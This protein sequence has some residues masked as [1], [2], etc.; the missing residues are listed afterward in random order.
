V[1]KIG[2][3]RLVWIVEGLYEK[4][5]HNRRFSLPGLQSPEV[6]RNLEQLYPEKKPEDLVKDYYVKKIQW[7]LGILL[8]GIVLA[9]LWW[10]KQ[11]MQDASPV[12]NVFPRKSF[13]EGSYQG[14]VTARYAG[15]KETFTLEIHPRTLN[16]EELEN[17]Y[18]QFCRN[19]IPLIKGKNES[20]QEIMSDLCL[21]DSYEGYPFAIQWKSS[22]PQVLRSSGE[23][24]L[25]EQTTEAELKA[26]LCYQE[27]NW[28]ISLPV[29][30]LSQEEKR[31]REGGGSDYERMR[32]QLLKMEEQS[33]DT[34][35]F[36]LPNQIEDWQIEW[37]TSGKGNS[38]GVIAAAGGLSILIY[39]LKD[40]DL[41]TNL[42]KQRKRMKR[43]YPEIIYKLSLYL[44]AGMTVKRAICKVAEDC[45]QKSAWSGQ[46][47]RIYEELLYIHRKLDMGMPEREVYEEFGKRTGVLE[48]I[49]L[50]SLLTQNLKKG[51]VLLV[52]RLREEMQQSMTDQIRMGKQLGEEAETRLLLPMG[53]L[54]MVVMIMVVLPAFH[55]MGG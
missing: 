47:E 51:S 35:E 34:E 55:A 49:R 4:T 43:K 53:L 1:E 12:G 5:R 3:S 39:F 29:Q 50:G 27:Q 38:L 32:Q 30:I 14:T 52:Q 25:P 18:G 26:I 41:K 46:K 31:N 13:E 54:L 28:E 22:C 10:W 45:E 6:V 8:A 42:E 40:R 11:T 19:I 44:G 7:S 48:Y 17:Y 37:K 20:L 15:E 36:L 23:V 33:R 24:L 21:A 16:L 9:F 2:K